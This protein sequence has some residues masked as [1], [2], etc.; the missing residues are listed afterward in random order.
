MV[1]IPSPT[2]N[3]LRSRHQHIQ[4]IQKGK[5]SSLRCSFRR[6]SFFN[7]FIPASLLEENSLWE[8]LVHLR[9]DKYIAASAI[10]SHLLLRMLNFF[11]PQSS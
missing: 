8:A 4:T 1:L 3:R 2:H 11:P 10:P 5:I 9:L 6:F 7:F